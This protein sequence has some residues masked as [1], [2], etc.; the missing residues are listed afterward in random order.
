MLET[1]HTLRVERPY[2][3]NYEYPKHEI[4]D[5]NTQICNQKNFRMT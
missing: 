2:T 4:D 1:E 3:T 5:Q